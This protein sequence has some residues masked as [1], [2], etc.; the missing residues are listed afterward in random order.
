M[1]P[2]QDVYVFIAKRI[3]FAHDTYMSP[4]R[5]SLDLYEKKLRSTTP[6]ALSTHV[7]FRATYVDDRIYAQR[8]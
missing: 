5:K 6:K 8:L 3:R 1:F 7:D 4:L 2:A